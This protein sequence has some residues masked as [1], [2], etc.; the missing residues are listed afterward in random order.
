MQKSIAQL[1]A[2]VAKHDLRDDR[3]PTLLPFVGQYVH[4]DDALHREV[5][6][7]VVWFHL[8]TWLYVGQTHTQ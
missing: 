8:Y 3:W 4:S 7:F 1:I 2:T 5:C 6:S